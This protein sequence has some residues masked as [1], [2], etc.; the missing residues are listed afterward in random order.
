MCKLKNAIITEGTVRL[1]QQIAKAN[2]GGRSNTHSVVKLLIIRLK[3][4]NNIE[5][6]SIKMTPTEATEKKN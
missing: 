5:H 1:R 2:R 3:Q 6:S 4:Y